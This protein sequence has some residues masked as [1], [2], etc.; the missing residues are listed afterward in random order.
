MNLWLGGR[1]RER[2]QETFAI[3]QLGTIP[4]VLQQAPVALAA[5]TIS[6]SLHAFLSHTSMI[7]LCRTNST[8]SF[9][10]FEPYKLDKARRRNC[11][12]IPER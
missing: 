9:L 4:G 3:R 10:C 1:A 7:R 8:T 6:P 5:P 11:L 12:C 2:A